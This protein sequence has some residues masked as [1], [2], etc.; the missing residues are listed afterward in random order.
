MKYKYLSD[1]NC[2]D[3]WNVLNRISTVQECDARMFNS[4][5]TDGNKKFLILKLSDIG[6]SLATK[7]FI[8]F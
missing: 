1:T 4:S 8:N 5:N 3:F 2:D 6:I 7:C